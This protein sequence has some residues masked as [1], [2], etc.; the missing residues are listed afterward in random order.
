MRALQSIAIALFALSIAA[1]ATA[2]GA[3]E[4]EGVVTFKGKPPKRKLLDMTSDPVCAETKVKDPSVIVGEGGAL[5]DVHVRIKVGDVPPQTAPKTPIRIEQRGCMYSPRVSGA[6][7]GQE[8][9]ITNGDA[10]MHNVHA[11]RVGKNKRTAFNR[12][13]P[14]SSKPIMSKKLGKAGTTFELKC[15]VHK[16]MGA[17]VPI[18][19]HP[20]FDVTGDNGK[21]SITG[22]PEGET[23]TLEA[24]HPVYGLKSQQV[25]AGDTNVK[26][27][28][29]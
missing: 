26:F 6:M 10:T 5:K 16:W 29:P 2:G 11:Y 28:F 18:T 20:F 13:Q 23:F 9:H 19:D 4:I 22:V 3:A 17:W 24:W 21:F 8:V 15:D 1:P 12:A 27:V 25:K 7:K 14:A